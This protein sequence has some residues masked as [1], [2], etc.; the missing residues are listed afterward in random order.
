MLSWSSPGV[1]LTLTWSSPDPYLTLISSLQ[2]EKSCVVGGWINPL[3][4]LSQGLVLTLRFTFGPEIDN[5][6]SIDQVGEFSVQ[7]R[8]QFL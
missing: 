4:T 7:L 1:H 6:T 5:T 8:S 2:V 3:Q